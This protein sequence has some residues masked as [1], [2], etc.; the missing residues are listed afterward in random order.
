M[1]KRI[2]KK[3]KEIKPSPLKLGLM[4]GGAGDG[5]LFH[6]LL[7]QQ[8]HKYLTPNNPYYCLAIYKITTITTILGERVFVFIH[9][10]RRLK[11]RKEK[12]CQEG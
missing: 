6:F 8:I 10:V 5:V 7:G 11:E 2:K 12:Q 4:K 1:T 3:K 9:N